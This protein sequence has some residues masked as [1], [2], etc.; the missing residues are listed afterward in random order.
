[1]HRSKY[2]LLAAIGVGLAQPPIGPRPGGPVPPPP[3][4]A[5][6]PG[7]GGALQGLTPAQLEL[8]TA[9]KADFEDLEKKEDGLGPAFNGISCHSCHNIPNTGGI[10]NVSVLRVGRRQN[11]AF[12]EPQGGSLLHL[13]ATEPKCQPVM[14][15]D[16]NVMARR[17]PTPLFGLGLVELI[18]D[19]LLRQLQAV[20]GGRAALVMDPA[21]RTQRVGRF[22][23][24]A[25]QATLLAFAGDAYVNEMGIT[26][27]IFPRE[28]GT[29]LSAQTLSECDSVADVEDVRDPATGRRGIDNFA[30]FMRFLGPPARDL[31]PNRLD[32]FTSTGCASC[33]LPTLTTGP[34][35]IPAL[36]RKP[37]DA[38]SDFLLHDIG[39]ADGIDQAAANGNEFRTAPLWGLRHR[40][41]LLHDGRA[42]NVTDAIEAHAGQASAARDRFR[43]LL[44][45]ERQALLDYLNT[46]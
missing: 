25:Q 14:P 42:L 32:L 7:P 15:K 41:M 22:G 6:A 1:M 3:P 17:I 43:R 40:R 28:T 4:G 20:T 34:S 18:P 36:D 13:F 30:N 29:G 27:D 19:D 45:Q 9:G 10:G 26:N 35:L 12:T 16:A 31:G 11:G 38:F 46:L 5:A 37:V 23:W 24:K 39:T 21:T 44:P 2:L 8:F 33:H